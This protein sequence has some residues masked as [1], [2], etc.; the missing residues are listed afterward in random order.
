MIFGLTGG[1]ASGKSTVT[2][3]FR[4]EGVPMIDAD[5]VAR[6]VVAPGS[7]G[8][9]MVREAFGDDVLQADGTLNR[10]KLGAIVFSNPEKRRVLDGIFGPL[11]ERIL[12][13]RSGEL[14]KVYSLV[15][16][17]AAILFEKG[18][19]T[20]YK[21]VVVVA[22]SEEIQLTR[23]MVRDGFTKEEAQ[24]RIK[25]QLPL[26]QKVAQ[27]DFVIWNNEGVEAL[28]DR[29]QEILQGLRSVESQLPNVTLAQER[30]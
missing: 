13:Q 27:A 3:M 4:D 7:T 30:P 18:L 28:K 15:G 6:E 9:Y 21:P 2:K 10:P 23:L 17:D 26:E 24:A 20:R 11:I 5:L 19:H 22:V 8:L 29:F 16:V 1:I 14:Q 25:S 12:A